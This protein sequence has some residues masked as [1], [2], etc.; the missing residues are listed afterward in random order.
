MDIQS[1]GYLKKW[2][3]LRR[4]GMIVL[5][6]I[7]LS[8]LLNIAVSLL[9]D[10]VLPPN[11]PPYILLFAFFSLGML[12]LPDLVSVLLII[13]IFLGVYAVY[14]VVGLLARKHDAFFLVG[15]GLLLVEGI[16]D[17]CTITT[18][19]SY[20][21]GGLYALA[22]ALLILAFIAGRKLKAAPP[23]EA[24]ETAEAD[25]VPTAQNE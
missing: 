13:L 5:L 10:F 3:R 23:T 14:P 9:T 7:T 18:P 1:S 17:Y 15:A 12:E 16:F 19:L 8:L 11:G 25:T 22:V 24:L 20:I 6:L 2:K 21:Y 4:A